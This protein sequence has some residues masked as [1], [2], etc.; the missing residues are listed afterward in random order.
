MELHW[1]QNTEMLILTKNFRWRL[2]AKADWLKQTM[3]ATRFIIT[4]NLYQLFA[5]RFHYSHLVI[6]LKDSITIFFLATLRMQV[7]KQKPVSSSK[8]KSEVALTL[9]YHEKRTFGNA[10]VDR[11]APNF[12][13]W[14]IADNFIRWCS[15]ILCTSCH[16]FGLLR[17]S[18]VTIVIYG[19][20]YNFTFV[21][22]IWAWK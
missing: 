16:T 18:T 8:W 20:N 12:I 2:Q 10:A 3:D 21:V 15:F 22:W 4:E 14:Q 11:P 1:S 6:T 17:T 19:L 7:S 5:R 9:T 13:Q